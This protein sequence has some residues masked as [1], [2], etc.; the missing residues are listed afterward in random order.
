[1]KFL[2]I[3][4]FAALCLNSHAQDHTEAAKAFLASLDDA[5]K[6][7]AMFPY[8]DEERFNWNFV[9]TSR[10]GISFHD[11]NPTQEKAALTLL[12]ASLSSQGYK[13]ASGIIE[14]EGI[15]REVEGRAKNDTYR[16]P[17]KYFFTIFGD[18]SAKDP[19]GW[20]IEGHH[21]ALNFSSINGMIVSSTPSFNGANPAVAPKTKASVLETESEL[22]FLLVNSLTPAQLE[23]ARFSTDALPEIVTGNSRKAELL[24]PRGIFSNDLTEVQKRFFRELVATYV[25]NY[26]FGFSEKLW[27]K[28]ERNGYDKMAFAWAGS[29]KPGAG[30]YYR[31]QGPVLL[32]EYDNTQ[33]NAN[34]A[35]SVVRDLTNDFAEDILRE[36]Y[37]KEHKRN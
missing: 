17:L 5:Q 19:W 32:I 12:K 25:N 22:G 8:A 23:K 31:I 10:K 18:P 29:L 21:L 35:H 34:H 37:Q 7:R 24:T 36:H 2:F 3:L 4:V 13:K 6:K 30:H 1:M 27:K 11:F 16:D 20:R 28:I 14:L 15:L 26:E 33:N 9:P